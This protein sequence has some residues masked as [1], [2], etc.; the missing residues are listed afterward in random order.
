MNSAKPLP[1]GLLAFA[2]VSWS[3]IEN[4]L[5]GCILLA[6]FSSNGFLL[7]PKG[8]SNDSYLG[9]ISRNFRL[10]PSSQKR[11]FLSFPL[12]VM[13]Y[14]APGYLILSGLALR[15]VYQVEEEAKCQGL[16]PIVS[17]SYLLSC[18]FCLSWPL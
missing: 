17:F 10:S 3:K 6:A 1:N 2:R 9:R 7:D 8:S 11:S 13:G 4:F 5:P 18:T 16:A 14:R 12:L 15:E